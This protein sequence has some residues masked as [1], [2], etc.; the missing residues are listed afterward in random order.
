[1]NRNNVRGA[2]LAER[3]ALPFAQPAPRPPKGLPSRRTRVVPAVMR[4]AQQQKLD[5]P[6]AWLAFT[7]NPRGDDAGLVENQ[8]VAAMQILRQ[9]AKDAMLYLTV[10]QHKQT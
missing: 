1:M 6:T 3:Y 5:T 7:E 2:E 10:A 4:R 8:Y 9:I